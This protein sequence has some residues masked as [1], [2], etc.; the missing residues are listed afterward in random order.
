MRCLIQPYGSSPTE[1]YLRRGFWSLADDAFL[2][3]DEYNDTADKKEA[4]E[5]NQEDYHTADA[6]LDLK[7][8]FG[9]VTAFVLYGDAISSPTVYLTSAPS[10]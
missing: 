9:E 7:A 4:A 5:D 3:Q 10:L 8:V 2:L 1:R 6:F